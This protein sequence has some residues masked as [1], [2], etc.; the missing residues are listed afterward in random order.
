MKIQFLFLLMGMLFLSMT[1]HALEPLFSTQIIYPAGRAPTS[2]F[3]SDLDGDGDIDLAVTNQG[4]PP[5]FIGS[6]SILLNTGNGTFSGPANYESGVCTKS[7]YGSDLD[8]DGDIDLAVANLGIYPDIKGNVSILLNNG[9]GTFTGADSYELGEAAT[10]VFGS[11]LD[12]DGD[13]DLAVQVFGVFRGAAVSIPRTAVSILLNTGE[14]TFAGAVNYGPIDG[15]YS[16][17]ASDLDGDGDND[18]AVPNHST[19]NVSILLNAGDGTFAGAVHYGAGNCPRSVYGADLDGDG[20]VDLATTASILLNAGNGTFAPGEPY[21]VVG[22][23]WAVYGSDLDVDGDI[24]LAMTN[25]YSSSASILLNDGDGTFVEAVNYGI[26]YGPISIC[27]SD[28]DGDGDIDLAVASCISDEISIFMNLTI[29]NNICGDTNGDGSI[30]VGDAVYL[31]NCIFKDGPAPNP[32]CAGDT[33]GDGGTN[34]GDAV[35]LIA[36]VFKGGPGPVEQCC[37]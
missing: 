28:L 32:I 26:I 11:D 29:F 21:G 25:W 10:S 9:D 18:L 17:Y 13:I 12:G 31:I 27:G 22:D 7:V 35:Y 14:G 20:D 5:Y 1:V 24:D 33:N 16:V 15:S 19:D 2:V 8:G 3:N 4:S 37:P 36:Y 34:V 23:L 6:I 30:N